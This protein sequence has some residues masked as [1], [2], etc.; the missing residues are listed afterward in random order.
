MKCT[1]HNRPLVTTF[2]GSLICIPCR[3]EA[4]RKAHAGNRWSVPDASEAKKKA[5]DRGY[6]ASSRQKAAGTKRTKQAA[7]AA[8]VEA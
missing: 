3:A 2:H 5:R 7:G 1:K 6:Y 8:E 4:N